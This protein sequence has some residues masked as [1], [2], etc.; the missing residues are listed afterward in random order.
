M[1]W[2]Y[3]IDTGTN[4]FGWAYAI[5]PRLAGTS[6][7]GAFGGNHKAA[8]DPAFSYAAGVAL[9]RLHK[10]PV[11]EPGKY[12][13]ALDRLVPVRTVYADSVSGDIEVLV[14]ASRTASPATTEADVEWVTELIEGAMPALRQPPPPAIIHLDYSPGNSI[15]IRDGDHWSVTGIVDWMTAEAGDGEADLARMLSLS[16]SGSGIALPFIEGYRSIQPERDGFRERFP[17]YMLL[18]RLLIWEYGQRNGVWFEPGLSMRDWIEP[19]TTI[20]AS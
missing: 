13:R 11:T 4:I 7:E 10:T 14:T 16:G 6:G 5:M 15:G 20:F 1:P 9:G 2:P 18:D 17:V 19:F 3:E 8:Q 12:D